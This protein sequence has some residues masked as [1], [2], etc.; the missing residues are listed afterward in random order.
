[1]HSRQKYLIYC[2]VFLVFF[3]LLENKTRSLLSFVSSSFIVYYFLFDFFNHIELIILLQIH[4]FCYSLFF[5]LPLSY[6]PSSCITH[7]V[8]NVQVD[9]VV[10]EKSP[11]IL[12][13]LVSAIFHLV[14]LLLL[15]FTF[16]EI[17]IFPTTIFSQKFGDMRENKMLHS[18]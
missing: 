3:V 4:N 8:V 18:N 17:Y 13:T 6:L 14:F 10:G 7:I 11:S 16:M 2:C 5:S 15:L 12:L 1:M 9:K